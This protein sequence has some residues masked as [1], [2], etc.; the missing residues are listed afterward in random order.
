M[1]N[2]ELDFEKA[3]YEH[4]LTTYAGLKTRKDTV[5]KK[6]SFQLLI[7]T[8][9]LGLIF[10][11]VNSIV[12]LN[13]YLMSIKDIR[14]LFFS[15]M[16]FFLLAVALILALTL[17]IIVLFR[18]QSPDSPTKDLVTSIYFADTDSAQ[19]KDPVFFYQRIGVAY[20]VAIDHFSGE[21]NRNEMLCR[22]AT[23]S[24]AVAILLLGMAIIVF[25]LGIPVV[26]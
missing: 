26:S 4:I 25:T 15:N 3:R 13:D 11:N 23:I 22:L 5:E 17:I 2:A 21:I 6:A 7:M 19:R 12:R 16:L 18:S 20:S 14:L 24:L 1:E 8:L 10:S 9:L